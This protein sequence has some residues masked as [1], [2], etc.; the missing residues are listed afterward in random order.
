MKRQP[1]R[2][3]RHRAAGDSRLRGHDELHGE[4][5]D[6]FVAACG[7]LNLAARFRERR[8]IANNDAETVQG[9]RQHVAVWIDDAAG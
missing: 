4:E 2:E 8:R 5:V 7:A 1:P 3:G 6:V 9:F